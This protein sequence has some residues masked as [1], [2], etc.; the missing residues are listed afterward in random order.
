MKVITTTQRVTVA[1]ETGASLALDSAANA[2]GLIL[3]G[4]DL[5][6]L[7]DDPTDLMADLLALAG[8]A[9]GPNGGSL[10][11]DGFSGGEL[12]PKSSIREIRI[13]Q[14]PFA[15]EYDKLGYGK[16][17]IFTK[18]GSDRYHAQLDYNLGTD[19]WN[20]RNPYSAVKA[21][22]LLNEFENEG[23]GPLGK[24]ASFSLDFQRNMVNN[25]AITNGVMLNSAFVPTPFTNMFEVKQRFTKGHAAHRL[26]VERQEH[27]GHALFH[28]AVEHSRRRHRQSG[29]A[30]RA[31]TISRI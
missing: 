13:N 27:A 17:E 18:P 11:I 8:P 3:R 30:L 21:P 31:V 2:S 14:N 12:P 28:H 6:A 5:D 20:A 16:I 15:A 4:A 29:S 9:A 1:E 7:S 23:G 22:L 19:W 26:R 24:H 10:F 25:G